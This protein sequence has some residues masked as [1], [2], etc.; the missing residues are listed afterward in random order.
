MEP[1]STGSGLVLPARRRGKPPRRHRPCGIGGREGIHVVAAGWRGVLRGV[2]FART[3]L[4]AAGDRWL[5]ARR[6][7]PG[8]RRRW[9]AWLAPWAV[10]RNTRCGYDLSG[11]PGGPGSAVTC[12]E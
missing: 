5:P 11:L 8:P 1:C 4:E 6:R 3:L 2:A 12:P 9:W 7:C 10:F